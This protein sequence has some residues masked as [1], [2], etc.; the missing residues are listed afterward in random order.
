M[1]SAEPISRFS[2]LLEP[3]AGRYLLSTSGAVIGGLAMEGRDADSLS[4]LDLIGLAELNAIILG[5]L[6]PR[7]AVLQVFAHWEGADVQ[8]RPRTRAINDYM[9]R[10][11]VAALNRR[12][13]TDESL[14]T[15]LEA[16]PTVPPGHVLSLRTLQH[17][18]SILDPR[19]RRALKALLSFDGALK[20]EL[21]EQSRQMTDLVQALEAIQGKWTGLIPSYAL[22]L[23]GLWAQARFMATLDPT[24]LKTAL[25]EAIPAHD[26]ANAIASGNIAPRII[27]DETY[28]RIGGPVMRYARIAAVKCVSDR[29]IHGIFANLPAQ[30]NYLIAS[31]FQP[32]TP[33]DLWAKFWWKRKELERKSIR[34]M[35]LLLDPAYSMNEDQLRPVLQRKF[36]E[37][38]NA[39]AQKATW[40]LWHCY[41]VAFDRDPTAASET[42]RALDVAL[43]TRGLALAWQDVDALDCFATIQPGGGRRSLLDSSVTLD[44]ASEAAPIFVAAKGQPTVEHLGGEEAQFVFETRTR[45][46][47]HFSPYAEGG[48]GFVA[49]V[50]PTTTGKSTL[51]N[52]L[53]A[54]FLKYDRAILRAIDIDPGTET[55]AAAFGD[56]AGV[57]KFEPG[58]TGLNVF[59]T[60]RG[61]RDLEFRDHL[62]DV[63]RLMIQ[64]NDVV[65]LQILTATDQEFLDKAIDKVLRNHPRERWNLVTLCLETPVELQRKFARWLPSDGVNAGGEYAGIFD[66]AVDSLGD[67]RRPLGVFNF[68]SLKNSRALPAV[69]F[70]AFH[71]TAQAFK[72]PELLDAPK[73]IDID[74]ARWLLAFEGYGKLI[75]SEF[76]TARKHAY[77]LSLWSQSPTHFAEAPGWHGIK[78]AVSTFFFLRDTTLSDPKT[79]DLYRSTFDLTPG[80]CET[81][82]QLRPQR[83]ALIKIPHLNLSKVAI[84]RPE[85]ASLAMVTSTPQDVLYRNARLPEL[86]DQ[87]GIA[88]A[89]EIIQQELDEQKAHGRTRR[90]DAA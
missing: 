58:G 5:A 68:Q 59:A 52:I 85:P 90:K 17:V 40:G 39:E 80:E 26:L 35:E 9:S 49:G 69:L 29:P 53:A 62:R 21:A 13:I 3:I 74:E 79:I 34:W 77:G 71:R 70:E 28:I 1:R 33:V 37:L 57:F 81:I 36:N 2:D 6:P 73:W 10:E 67:I 82:R 75:E 60:C 54:H 24:R 66:G 16:Y 86:R 84:L 22:S 43:T 32:Y 50:G 65:E 76:L 44:V 14:T 46:A 55:L 83:E 7:I 48:R 18:A 19:S 41:I 12:G 45:G 56:E 78:S 42:A 4:A 88:K 89:L 25:D 63:L 30:G 51:K 11:R 64:A 61:L 31:R 15:F 8:L 23:Q 38:N 87:V 72:S 20:L 27:G 47:L